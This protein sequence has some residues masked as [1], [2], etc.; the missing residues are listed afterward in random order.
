MEVMGTNSRVFALAVVAMAGSG[1][2]AA[3]ITN[4]YVYNEI[5]SLTSPGAD[6]YNYPLISRNANRIVFTQTASGTTTLWAIN[7]DGSGLTRLDSESSTPETTI[8]WASA[9][10][11]L[12]L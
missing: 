5:T 8:F 12:K 4:T 10:M 2:L 9:T 3:Q 1:S 11:A 7:P 6:Y